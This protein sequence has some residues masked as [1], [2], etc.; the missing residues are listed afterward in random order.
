MNFENHLFISYA[1]IDNKYSGI[2]RG[3]RVLHNYLGIQPPQLLGLEKV[4]ALIG[5]YERWQAGI[6]F[7][8]RNFI[9]V[10]TTE[11]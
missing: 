6:R 1:H 8:N 7:T 2:T 11:P 3:C 5:C 10:I 9:A 4:K